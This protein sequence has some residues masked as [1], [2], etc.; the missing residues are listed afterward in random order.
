MEN[1][2]GG[3]Q[4]LWE[5]ELKLVCLVLCL[6]T[7]GWSA[8]Q[9]TI[10]RRGGDP[11]SFPWPLSLPLG[12][13]IVATPLFLVVRVLVLTKIPF[14]PFA[15]GAAALCGVAAIVLAIRARFLILRR[16]SLV[17]ALILTAVTIYGTS[18][19]LLP[20]I[21]EPQLRH[22]T[23]GGTDSTGYTRV[24]KA[25]IDG[26]Y[27][28]PP[29][30]QI[31]MDDRL[32]RPA[33]GW[34]YLMMA[35]EDRPGAYA[36]VALLSQWLHVNVFQAYLLT[37]ALAVAL[38]A[39]LLLYVPAAVPLP[40]TYR[41]LGTVFG[42]IM[43]P[44]CGLI[45]NF[46]LQFLG[47]VL[48][49]AIIAAVI[50]AIA[51]WILIA[52][53]GP[54]TLACGAFAA[55]VLVTYGYDSRFA[56]LVGLTLMPAFALMTW[57]STRRARNTAIDALIVFVASALPPLLLHSW[58]NMFGTVPRFADLTPLSAFIETGGLGISSPVTEILYT[59]LAVLIVGG[60]T[61]LD[62]VVRAFRT[63]SADQHAIS[64]FVFAATLTVV[65]LGVASWMAQ[66]GSP[67]GVKKTMYFVVP[68]LAVLFVFYFVVI[69]ASASGLRR[70]AAVAAFGA[71]SVAVS[72]ASLQREW[73]YT[74]FI[75]K[76]RIGTITTETI[77]QLEDIR[78]RPRS[79]VMMN[80]GIL[81][82]LQIASILDDSG[83]PIFAPFPQWRHGSTVGVPD[84]G[85]KV[86]HQAVENSFAAKPGG[87]FFLM[88]MS[89]RA[90][91][92]SKY[93]VVYS[94]NIEAI[95]TRTI[96]LDITFPGGITPPEPILTSGF[97]GDG[98]FVYVEYLP[99]SKA[100][101]KFNYW[102][103]ST[104]YASDPFVRDS[105]PHSV[106][107]ILDM[108]AGKVNVQLDGHTILEAQGSMRFDQVEHTDI[109]ANRLGGG[110]TL[111]KFT[112]SIANV[113]GL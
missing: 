16:L 71:A 75:L 81:E 33:R 101:L 73:D 65:F 8:A 105:S 97:K 68:A 80:T 28:Q 29:P 104:V 37:G 89:A 15:S 102:G 92:A 7:V 6:S 34:T 38:L 46:Y 84:A 67:Y 1:F 88:D 4:P 24:A 18:L 55:S 82:F 86:V 107:A 3:F 58:Q 19:T 76:R 108:T 27:F 20:M 98:F 72:I 53:A 51:A 93:N 17:R 87:S 11:A 36:G 77:A 99:E 41:V 62:R 39:A 94:E 54:A 2:I 100:R 57:T 23:G 61:N 45:A 26:W 91:R 22:F 63:I 95:A 60:L 52:G 50:P 111:P 85:A 106:A 96:R 90:A 83:H 31:T 13:A 44:A 56:L 79:K 103:N 25:M 9:L 112:G 59:V 47:Q 48:C 49:T 5:L 64:S 69:S 78:K 74:D 70:I 113:R 32:C 10:R 110:L 43:L 42:L 14:F 40:P 12:F 21:R 109:G 35:I 66:A 30:Q